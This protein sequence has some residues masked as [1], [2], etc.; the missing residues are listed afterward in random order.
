METRFDAVIAGAGPAGSSAAIILAQA[1]WRVAL[2]EKQNFPRRKVCG[3][4]LAASN[5]PLLKTLGVDAEFAALAGPKLRK[6][7]LMH[8]PHCVVANLPPVH[9]GMSRWGR[10]LGREKLDT[11]LLSQARRAGVEVMQPWALQ[12]FEGEPGKW[13]CEVRDI[14]TRTVLTL[15]AP[16]AIDAHGSW[17]PLPAE[18]AEKLTRVSDLLAFKANYSGASLPTGLL[19]VLSFQGG[20]G[21]MVMADQ[22]MLTLACCVRRDRLEALRL[23]SPGVSAGEV[24]EALLQRECTGVEVALRTAR[25]IGPWLAAGPLVPGIRLRA[26]D[27]IFRIGNAAAEAHPIIG[28]GMSMA[29][30]SAWLLSTHLTGGEHSRLP[31]MGWQRAVGKAYA[32]DWNRQ[33]A[34][35]VRLAS[36]L[37]HLAMRPRLA[38]PLMTLIRIWPGLLPLGARWGGKT[39]ITT[40]RSTS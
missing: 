34:G 29:L 33:F 11:L 13:H 12:R 20:Y 7:A 2:V 10:A 19:P 39:Q 22:G 23:A 6:V 38:S 37:A 3:E 18:R 27:P 25:R 14:D 24:L 15:R 21:G 32:R 1:G 8:G 26:E 16:V 36:A 31:D 5:L 30:Q 40:T 28:E 35:R 9:G 17:E 4:C